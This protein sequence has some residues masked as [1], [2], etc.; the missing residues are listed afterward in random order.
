MRLSERS[1]T[2]VAVLERV[3]NGQLEEALKDPLSDLLDRVRSA[4]EDAF[5]YQERL[6]MPD[7]GPAE[8]S[9]HAITIDGIEFEA[10]ESAQ[11]EFEFH[12]RFLAEASTTIARDS[13][14][15]G[16]LEYVQGD[17]V[18]SGRFTFNL[19]WGPSDQSASSTSTRSGSTT[20]KLTC[21]SREAVIPIGRTSW[22]PIR[23]K[24]TNRQSCTSCLGSRRASPAPSP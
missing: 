4:V 18:A 17:A 6:G 5:E 13:P 15:D 8:V 10:F 2:A 11:L 7:V 16:D 22:T 20:G 12:G 14:N 1:R 21:R 3:A 19:S 24:R 9:W 23:R